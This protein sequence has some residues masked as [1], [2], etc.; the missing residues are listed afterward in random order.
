MNEHIQIHW[1]F[2]LVLI[3][4]H[5]FHRKSFVYDHM[6]LIYRCPLFV[7]WNKFFWLLR[8]VHFIL[9]P[10]SRPT[11]TILN[12]FFFWN[13]CQLLISLALTFHVCQRRNLTFINI[14]PIKSEHWL[15]NCQLG[16]SD[17]S[18]LHISFN[19]GRLLHLYLS[20]VPWNLG[21]MAA[22]LYGLNFTL[23]QAVEL[24]T[25]HHRL[26]VTRG[27][28]YV[29]Y[30]VKRIG[31][32]KGSVWVIQLFCF[33][34]HGEELRASQKVYLPSESRGRHKSLRRNH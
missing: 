22:E 29:L 28:S 15:H 30:F 14:R 4:G 20:S 23:A 18:F 10:K 12:V 33:A 1:V 32:V 6:R 9:F 25:W 2:Y 17:C 5:P 34:Q 24:H 21:I 16:P 26:I 8:L 11:Y 7:L 19:W 27:H 13:A 31:S 3:R